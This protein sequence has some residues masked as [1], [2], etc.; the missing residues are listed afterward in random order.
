MTTDTGSN[1]RA[2]IGPMIAAPCPVCAEPLCA[3]LF[4]A[5]DGPLAT[6][7]WP[8]SRAAAAAMPRLPLDFVQCPQCSHVFNHAFEYDHVPYSDKPNRMFN[9]GR[10]WHG[11]LALTRD[12]LL[13]FLPTR[14]TVVEIGC[15]DGHFLHG[16]AEARP[17]R[18][19]GF[20][21]HGGG[22]DGDGV[23]MHARL[24][25]PFID[26]PAIA[27]DLIIIRHVLEHLK[28][29]R[30]LLAQL[31]WAVANADRPCLL[32][33]EAPCIDRVF[34]TD[35]LADFY[36]EHVSHF[37]TR[38]FARL[39]SAHGELRQLAHGY[40]GEVV[41]GLLALGIAPDRR[42]A[43]AA[44]TQFAARSTAN[45][46]YIAGQLD[47]L[48]RAGER[49]AIWG[50][51][52]KGAAFMHHYGVDAERFPCV[53]DSDPDKVGSYVPGSGQRIEFRD[54]LKDAPVDV[55]II[56]TQWRARDIV[57]EMGREG[58]TVGRILIEHQ[59]ALI[60]FAADAHPY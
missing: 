45:R 32:F 56:P 28:E 57:A 52:G 17:G 34:A 13:E 58:I 1:D 7:A 38:S 37:T 4:L 19:E 31:A 53:V 50:G 39:L 60:D 49:V 18:Y 10:I 48:A 23:R 24:F 40:R 36:Y 14:P 25:D 9:R 55:L 20:D 16:L 6:I 5:D 2:G 30:V 47:A 8:E 11:H 15:A 21:P 12:L 27:P 44:A 42:Q 35:R 33:V 54:R 22:S 29:P 59:G 3:R 46:Q 51:T 41:Y 26:V 43:V